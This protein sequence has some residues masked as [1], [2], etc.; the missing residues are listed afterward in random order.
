MEWKV[1]VNN[2][3]RWEDTVKSVT[4]IP[5][6]YW[7]S[8]LKGNLEKVLQ[9]RVPHSRRVRS[10]G[11]S[12]VIAVDDRKHKNVKVWFQSYDIDWTAVEKQFLAWGKLYTRGKELRVTIIFNYIEDN[13]LSGNVAGRGDKRGKSSVTNKMLNE[14]EAQLDAEEHVSGQQSIWRAVYGLIRCPSPSCHLG[15]HLLHYQLRTH[16]SKRLIAYVEG[17]GVL[18]CQDD[19]PETIREELYMEEQQRLE[20]LQ[21]KSNK[22]LAFR[23]CPSIN[24]SFMG[25]QPSL[26]AVNSTAASVLSSEQNQQGILPTIDRP[27]DVA[28]REYNAWQETNVIDETLKAQFQLACDVTLANGLDLEQI[29]E[30]RDPNFFVK[31]GVVVG[32][33]R[34]FVG[35]IVK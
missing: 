24:I 35:D 6:A 1:K 16:H 12:V 33:A 32:I 4:L 31:N 14:R 20:H 25:A 19:V 10:D 28:V 9:E 17:G 11:T 22:S 8:V 7:S 29:H 23:S 13:L 27:R 21:S 34:R 26:P 3:F 15:P 30:N 5:S 2:R 18:E